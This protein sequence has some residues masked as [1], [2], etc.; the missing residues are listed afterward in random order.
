MNPWRRFVDVVPPPIIRTQSGPM[1][2]RRWA[3]RVLGRCPT[4]G[5]RM[6]QGRCIAW[7]MFVA[8]V[9]REW[10]EKSKEAGR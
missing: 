7:M 4:C 3:R 5:G 10:E 6:V 2:L 8:R 9:R 1:R